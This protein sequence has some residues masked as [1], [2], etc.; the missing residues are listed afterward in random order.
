M[1]NNL[2]SS[3]IFLGFYRLKN[4]LAETVTAAIIEAFS[5]FIGIDLSKKVVAQT[6]D[7]ASNMQG[8]Y[9]GVQK[10]IRDKF[11]PFT[12]KLHCVNHQ[13]QISVKEM[14]K[15]PNIIKRVTDNCYVIAKIIKYSPKRVTQLKYVGEEL[16]SIK[17]GITRKKNEYA[18][19][20]ANILDFCVTRWTVRAGLLNNIMKNYEALLTLFAKILTVPAERNRLNKDKRAEIGGLVKHLQ[21]FEFFF[22]LRLSIEMYSIIDKKAKKLKGD[23]VNISMSLGMARKLVEELEEQRDNF[24]FFGQMH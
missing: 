3:V 1:I 24:D 11:A 19:L 2:K 16:A 6:Y 20:K 9:D 15:Q 8:R 17:N 18:S 14:N 23:K 12:A 21:T 22:S 10:M 7:G 13:V 4:I 5:Y